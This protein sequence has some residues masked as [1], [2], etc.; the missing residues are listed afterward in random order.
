MPGRARYVRDSLHEAGTGI[1]TSGSTARV[2]SAYHQQIGSMGG[3][4]THALHDPHETMRKV[5]AG[6]TARFRERVL[7]ADPDLTDEVE[8]SRRVARL[9]RAEMIRLSRL[10]VKAR[11]VKAAAAATERELSSTERED[12]IADNPTGCRL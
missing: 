5:R 1:V 3:L 8:I 9:Q 10:A 11:R 4:T 6:K 2:P 12:C 7:K